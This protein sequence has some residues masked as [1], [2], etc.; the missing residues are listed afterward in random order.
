M[1]KLLNY[2]V[3]PTN[4]AV[5]YLIINTQWIVHEV[6]NNKDSLGYNDSR[7]RQLMEHMIILWDICM[8]ELLVW[9]VH[10]VFNRNNKYSRICW[11][12]EHIILN[13]YVR[14]ELREQLGS[15]NKYIYMC[16]HAQAYN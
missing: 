9:L 13:S 14:V 12:H 7:I 15:I 4:L 16:R 2:E 11:L 1:Q 8:R 10:T 3:D 6:L 5:R